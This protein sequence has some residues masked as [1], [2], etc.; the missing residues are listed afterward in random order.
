MLV[1]KGVRSNFGLIAYYNGV[2]PSDPLLVWFFDAKVQSAASCARTIRFPDA[3]LSSC[4]VANSFGW[5]IN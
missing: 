4:L 5:L 1:V 3:P 2:H